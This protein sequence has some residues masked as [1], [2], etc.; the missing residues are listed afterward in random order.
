MF[1]PK[2]LIRTHE[3]AVAQAVGKA[4]VLTE[5]MTSWLLMFISA[6]ALNCKVCHCHDLM[7]RAR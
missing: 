1:N 6:A 4:H 3:S 7:G 2:D 5:S